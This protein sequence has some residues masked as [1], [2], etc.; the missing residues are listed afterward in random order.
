DDHVARAVPGARETLAGTPPEPACTALPFYADLARARR[1]PHATPLYDAI[2]GSFAL[3]WLSPAE[4]HGPP[5]SPPAHPR[6]GAVAGDVGQ[7]LNAWDHARPALPIFLVPRPFDPNAGKA[8]IEVDGE[9]GGEG[10]VDV[11]LSDDPKLKAFFEEVHGRSHLGGT[12][13]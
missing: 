3:L 10:Y 4:F 8:P 2:G 13:L 6:A 5:V 11:V 12:C 7:N 9:G 1:H